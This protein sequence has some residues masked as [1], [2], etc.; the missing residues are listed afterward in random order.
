MSS[1]VKNVVV[2]RDYQ[3]SL[4]EI[5]QLIQQA[6]Y[7]TVHAVNAVMTATYWEIGRRIVEIEQRG[8]KRAEYGEKLIPKLAED[9]SKS[10]GK[11]FGTAN[12]KNFRL[13][14]LTYSHLQEKLTILADTSQKSQTV[15]GQS[16]NYLKTKDFSEFLQKLSNQF[17]LPW[18]AYVR[19]LS[20]KDKEARTF[21]EDETLRGGWSVRQLDRQ[22]KSQFYTRTLLSKN[23]MAMLTKGVRPKSEDKMLPE[24]LI[25]DPYI[26]EFLNLKDEYSENELEEA[27][28][29]HMES[30]LL[31][32]GNGFAFVGRQKRL[33]IENHWFRVDLVFYHRKLNCLVLIELK[34]RDFS[35]TDVAQMNMYVNYAKANWAEKNENPPIGLILSTGKNKTMA[36]YT[37]EG[38]S[39]K[40]LTAEYQRQLPSIEFLTQEIEKTRKILEQR[41]GNSKHNHPK[42]K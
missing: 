36:R 18:S 35:Y 15:S 22:I 38:I 40:I 34:T 30:F 31:E 16:F 41:K 37:L 7:N 8:K 13:F 2:T 5:V 6:R 32:L 29:L 39:N 14:Y 1:K 19:L 3:K 25:K 42:N 11:N 20:V 24:E 17:P 10:C 28:I 4:V 27:L 23:K 21:Y 12:L 33:R 9:L 26:L